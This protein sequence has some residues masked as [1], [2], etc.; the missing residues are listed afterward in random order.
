VFLHQKLHLE[1]GQATKTVGVRAVPHVLVG[2]QQ[3]NGKGQPHKS[4]EIHFFGQLGGATW[5]GEGRP[6]A[7]GRITAKVPKGLT[8]AQFDIMVNEHQSTRYRWSDDAS[9]RN[10]RKM[11]ANVIDQDT[12]NIVVKYYTAPILLVRAQAP[13]GTTITNF[14]SSITYPEGRKQYE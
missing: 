14:K 6:D 11:T 8:N 7:N 2:I 13:D 9:W 3:L 12:T 1:E 5:W 10:D 4:H